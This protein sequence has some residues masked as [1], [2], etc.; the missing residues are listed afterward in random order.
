MT[1][2]ERDE[3]DKQQRRAARMQAARKQ[4]IESLKRKREEKRLT[5]EMVVQQEM[6]KVSMI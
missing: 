5:A 3:A 2:R 6:V 1:S 4:A